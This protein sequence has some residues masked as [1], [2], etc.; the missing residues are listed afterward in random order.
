[1]IDILESFENIVIPDQSSI[2]EEIL[3]TRH[4][5]ISPLKDDLDVIKTLSV[6][7]G[8]D[9]VN[10]VER[11]VDDDGLITQEHV[12]SVEEIVAWFEKET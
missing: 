6:I 8:E 10:V 4:I 11:M 7:H 1:M 2:I 9:Y 3:M 5:A 12:P